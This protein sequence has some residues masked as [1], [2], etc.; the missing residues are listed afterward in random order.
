MPSREVTAVFFFDVLGFSARIRQDTATA[1]DALSDLAAILT[2]DAVFAKTGHWEHRYALSD[3][4]FLTHREPATALRLAGD[5]M[6]NLTT[7]GLAQNRPTMVRGGLAFGEVDHVRN[8]FLTDAAEPTNLV[9]PGVLEAIELEKAGK[10]PRIFLA[11]DFVARVRSAD[12]AIARWLVREE[13]GRD[14]ELL[15]LLPAGGPEMFSADEEWI[16]DVC[17]HAV[18]LFEQ[19][20]GE[21]DAGVHYEEF[22]LLAARS[23]ARAF[24]ARDA[25]DQVQITRTRDSFFDVG[26]LER[27]SRS[28]GGFA[29]GLLKRLGDA[30]PQCRII[31]RSRRGRGVTAEFV[32]RLGAA[33]HER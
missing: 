23:I 15:W 9:G 20:G 14:A 33:L 17:A 12:P 13:G 21:S 32:R 16:S 24:A 3:S 22:V 27:R 25:D 26:G 18:R 29:S 19:Y 4:V 30:L 28:A 2:T 8:V 5:L 31:R 7:F 6:F 10:G 11:N 1:V